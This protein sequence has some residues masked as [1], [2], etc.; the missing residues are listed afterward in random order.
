MC[1]MTTLK[2]LPA[3]LLATL[4]SLAFATTY[5]LTV[6]DMDGQKVVINHEPQRVILQ[7]GREILSLALLDRDNPFQRVVSWNNLMKKQD[8]GSWNLLKKRWP[9]AEKILDMGFSDQGE[10]NLETVIAKKPDLMIAQLRAKPALKQTGVLTQ[11]SALNIPVLFVDDELHP[12]QNTAASITLLG[13][14]LNKE[15]NARAYTDFYTQKLNA[16]QAAVKNVSPKPSV[17][18][19]PIAGIGGGG[20]CCFTHG[21]NGWGALIEATGAKNIGSD[22]LPGTSGTIAVEK[23]INLNP[24]YYV[25]SG[26]KRGGKTSPVIPLG[27]NTEVSEIKASFDNLRN[28][29]GVKDIPAVKAGKVAA[30]YHHFYNH[31]YNIIGIE[32]L[33]KDFYPQQFSQTNPTADYHYI[34]RTFTKLPDEPINIEYHPQ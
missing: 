17:F 9:D 15:D 26:S 34:I 21:H 7:D 2:T 4:P 25:M 32:M 22:L 23:V 16:I 31:P 8:T 11:L 13:K 5:P 6:T 30:V 12:V 1:T 24:D 14:V 33:A 3:L 20:E 29:T 19:E 10:V 27:Y 28:R 18:V